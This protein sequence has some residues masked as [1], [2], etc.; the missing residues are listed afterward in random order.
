LTALQSSA[1]P[2]GDREGVPTT[3][4][5]LAH[6]RLALGGTIAGLVSKA[7]VFGLFFLWAQRSAV[8]S[9]ALRGAVYADAFTF[10]VLGIWEWPFHRTRV[11]LAGAFEA[12]LVVL[13]LNRGSV[14][15][16]AT[17]VSVLATS[18]LFFLLVVLL[19]TAAWTMER[20]LG[21]TG[22]QGPAS[23]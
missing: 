11:T 5:V 3:A 19:K 16:I 9:A 13:Y 2:L 10:L 15:G 20:V 4:E 7:I 1:G 8:G 21:V 14:F 6:K 12:A 18:M 22:V 17:D 23:P